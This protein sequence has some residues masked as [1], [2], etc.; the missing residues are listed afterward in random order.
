VVT[1]LRAQLSH[2]EAKRLALQRSLGQ[3]DAALAAWNRN[4]KARLS[5]SVALKKAQWIASGRRQVFASAGI[6]EPGTYVVDVTGAA[7]PVGLQNATAVVDGGCYEISSSG[8]NETT[9]GGTDSS[10]ASSG[11]SSS[12]CNPNY[13]GCLIADASDY[14]CAGGSGDG[15]Y[16]TGT[17]EVLAYDEYGL[18]ADG[19]G[20]G[21][22]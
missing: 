13:S 21:C 10:T 14:D 15:P 3:R 19:D 1:D 18:D 11:G 20:Y 16:Y 6:S 2:A 17:V 22:D 5:T 8:P 7:N 9:C 12:N 4:F